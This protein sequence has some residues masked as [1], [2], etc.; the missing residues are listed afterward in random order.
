MEIKLVRIAHD[1]IR[2]DVTWTDPNIV[3]AKVAIAKSVLLGLWVKTE[4]FILSNKVSLVN[5]RV[6]IDGHVEGD[7]VRE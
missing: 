1:K 6:V 4:H 3:H 7:S 5:Q 2:Q